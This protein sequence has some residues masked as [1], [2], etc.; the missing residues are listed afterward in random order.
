MTR[1]GTHPAARVGGLTGFFLS[2]FVTS[3]PKGLQIDQLVIVEAGAQ[4]PFEDFHWPSVR[5]PGQQIQ[6]RMPA[7]LA[8]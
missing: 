2:W 6:T 5:L 3:V 8:L 1:R 7:D 4:T